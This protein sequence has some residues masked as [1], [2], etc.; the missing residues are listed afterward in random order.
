[1]AR[2]R[3]YLVESDTE[4]GKTV[5]K[6][7]EDKIKDIFP[8]S[9][10]ICRYNENITD[11]VTIWFTFGKN[12]SEYSNG[13]PQNDIGY[14]TYHIFGKGQRNFGQPLFKV[15]SD[16]YITFHTKE[17]DQDNPNAK[18]MAVK[19]KRVKTGWRDFST[20]NVDDI[21]RKFETYFKRVK[22]MLK[23][24]DLDIPDDIRNK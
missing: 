21:Y 18:Y 23:D 3:E 8:N 14:S 16:N 12:K 24:K 9:N 19:G 10:V 7:L 22:G 4:L 5:A 6:T 17:I 2:F 13:I 1:M 15:E 20:T 11:S